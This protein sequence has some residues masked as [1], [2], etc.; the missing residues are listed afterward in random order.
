MWVWRQCD[1]LDMGAANVLLTSVL[2]KYRS[3]TL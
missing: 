2:G 1:M 3:T